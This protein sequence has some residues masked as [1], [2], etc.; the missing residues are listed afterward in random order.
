MYDIRDTSAALRLLQ[1]YLLEIS[2]ATEGLPH[3][4]IDGVAGEETT[5]AIRLFQEQNGLP[6]TG[7]ADYATWEEILRH[8]GNAL[9]ARVA[10]PVL[11]PPDS[12]PLSLRDTGSEVLILQTLL[13]ALRERYPNLPR[14]APSGRYDAETAHAVRVYQGHHSLPPSGITDDKTWQILTGEYRRREERNTQ[15]SEA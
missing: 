5:R 15:R 8:Y 3:I 6:T 4:S 9:R 11:L 12:L 2:Y 1:T 10:V 14:V 13:T 7:F